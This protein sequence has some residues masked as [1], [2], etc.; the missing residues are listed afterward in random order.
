MYKFRI[1]IGGI[2]IYYLWEAMLVSYLS[3]K[4]VVLPFNNIRELLDN[5]NFRIGVTPGTSHVDYFK[6]STN[7]ILQKAFKERIEPYLDE[8]ADATNKRL[9]VELPLKDRSVAFYYWF[10]VARYFKTTYC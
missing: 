1:M 4:V 3:T 2:L 5:T 9:Q 6:Y 7:P 8:Y 10:G